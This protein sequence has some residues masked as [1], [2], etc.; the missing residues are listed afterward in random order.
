MG[1]RLADKKV[2]EVWGEIDSLKDQQPAMSST[3][4]ESFLVEERNTLASSGATACGQLRKNI[5]PRPFHEERRVLQLIS[6]IYI[7]ELSSRYINQQL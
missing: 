7:L 5:G 4:R 2:A 1:R 3:V 6:M